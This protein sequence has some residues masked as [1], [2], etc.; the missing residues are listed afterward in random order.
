MP[1]SQ[2]LE[3]ETRARAEAA[4]STPRRQGPGGRGK[5]GV[6]PG[7]RAPTEGRE[8][9]A[10]GG[11]AGSGR[12]QVLVLF[13]AKRS[14]ESN[15]RTKGRDRLHQAELKAALQKGGSRRG[16]LQ[17]IFKSV[18]SWRAQGPQGPRLSGP[19]RG[20]SRR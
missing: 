10:K 9:C 2:R 1:E 5:M 17:E 19:R 4:G 20:R 15:K 16:C 18:A 14:A 12:G 13:A 11:A 7:R 3:E 6:L 8:G